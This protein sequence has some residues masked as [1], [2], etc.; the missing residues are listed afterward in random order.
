MAYRTWKEKIMELFAKHKDEPVY[1]SEF[2]DEKGTKFCE[3]RKRIMGKYDICPFCQKP[4]KEG[5]ILLFIN[6]WK[7]FPNINVHFAC[8]N[9]FPTK[10]AAIKYLHEDYEVAKAHKHWFNLE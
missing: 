10:E 6:N 4:L 2:K 5:S 8:S 9:G 1:F 7:L 3:A